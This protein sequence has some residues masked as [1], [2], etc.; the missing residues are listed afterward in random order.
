MSLASPSAHA[1]ACVLLNVRQVCAMFGNIHPSTL[2][3]GI[4]HGI[5]P[6]PVRI[7]LASSRWLASECSDVLAQLISRRAAP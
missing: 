7:G 5:Y 2:Y 1:D 6:R 4:R 3:R